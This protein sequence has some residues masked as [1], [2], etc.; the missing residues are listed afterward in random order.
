MTRNFISLISTIYY[1][2]NLDGYKTK[3]INKKRF[4]STS[5]DNFCQIID[6]H[7]MI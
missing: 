1:L 2:G 7:D 3:Y 6:S 4:M 5:V